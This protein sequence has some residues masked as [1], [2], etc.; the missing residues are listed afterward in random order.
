MAVTEDGEL[1]GLRTT[2]PEAPHSMVPRARAMAL[3]RHSADGVAVVSAPAGYGKTSAV[4]EWARTDARPVAWLDLDVVDN[5]PTML[6]KRLV[7]TLARVSDPELSRLT[8]WQSAGNMNAA[9]VAHR[10]G[11]VVRS[12]SRPFVLVVDDVHTVESPAAV[13]L[14]DTLAVNLPPGSK[15]VLV[16][17]GVHLPSVPRMR[18]R[19]GLTEVS[20]AD[21]VFD[22]GEVRRLLQEMGAPCD[23]ETS[24][25]IARSTEGWAVGVRFAGLAVLSGAVT[26]GAGPA[27]SHDHFVAEYVH[28][29]WMRGLGETD[30]QFLLRVSV[31]DQ[32]SAPLCDH[33]LD[34]EG[35]GAVLDKLY[36]QRLLVVPLDHRHDCFRMHRLLREVL[37][38]ELERAHPAEARRLHLRASQWFEGIGDADRAV[39]HA[40]AAGDHAT[41]E[42]LVMQFAPEMQTSGRGVT[43]ARWLEEFPTNHLHSSAPLLL[44]GALAAVGR[45]SVVAITW[46]NLSQRTIDLRPDLLVDPA[47]AVQLQAFRALLNTGPV[48]PAIEEAESA[49]TRLPPGIWHSAATLVRGAHEFARGNLELAGTLLAE[50]EAEAIVFGASTM[51]VTSAAMRAAVAAA[52]GQQQRANELARRARRRQTEGGLD[53]WPTVALST[54]M[55]GL[56]HARNA[57]RDAAIEELELTGHS[58]AA[59]DGISSWVNVPARLALV[60]TCLLL[61]EWTLADSH[62]KETARLLAAQPDAV[63]WHRQL[64][65]LVR[66]VTAARGVEASGP[67]AL[68]AAELRVLNFLPTNLTIEEIG[69]RLYVSR[70]TVKSHVG[71]IYRKLGTARRQET[72]ELARSMGLLPPDVVG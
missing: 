26:P 64:E 19:S 9:L 10:F 52:A 51:E 43:V 20:A 39:R 41:A 24:A 8:M 11:A 18:T 63:E 29:E 48:V 37:R 32:L 21:L 60:E 46:A 35:A 47:V 13:A 34:I 22:E 50:S 3:L 55:S 45:D 28:A 57:R 25:E 68:S 14:L 23:D 59:I 62:A 38:D 71:A 1:A 5:D 4:A 6:L 72:V 54:A 69:E 44:A 65:V 67:C 58:L 15:V 36:D 16:G 42:R 40:L 31:V 56:A 33:L 49:G 17:R 70:H 12:C 30:A 7:D 27:A 66:R 61:G 53:G 2:H